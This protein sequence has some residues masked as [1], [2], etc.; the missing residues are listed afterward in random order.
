MADMTKKLEMGANIAIVVVAM[1][2]ASVLIKNY[3]SSRTQSP[4]H[5]PVGTKVAL[6]NVNWQAGDETVVLGLSTTCHYCTESAGFYRELAKVCKERNVRTLAVFPQPIEAAEKYMKDKG[7][8]FDEIRQARL[9]DLE[10][11]GTPTLLLVD[12]TGAVKSVWIG[13]LEDNIEKKLL[14]NLAMNQAAGRR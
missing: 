14:A 9:A 3:A 11:S 8:T 2:L 1:V 10:I 7:I 5:I 6:P 12:K 4:P 13:K